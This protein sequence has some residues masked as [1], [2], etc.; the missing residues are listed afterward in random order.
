[1]TKIIK[2]AACLCGTVIGLNLLASQAMAAACTSESLAA[3]IALA[4]TGCTVGD[5]TFSNFSEIGSGTGTVPTPA[6]ITV[7]PDT[8]SIPG[9]IGLDFNSTWFAGT[10]QTADTTITFDVSIVGGGPMLIT[11]ASTVQSS[12]GFTGTG[13]ATVTEGI[14]AGP[15]CTPTTSTSTVN[16]AGTTVLADT[17]V[18]A[19]TGAIQA[20]KDL[21]VVGGS[22]GTA[23]ISQVF[24][25]F[26][27]T[28]VPEPGSI[29]L[30]GTA[31]LG[32]VNFA[33]KRLAH[34]A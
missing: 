18:F 15:P 21:G 17:K 3:Y 33:R 24:D 20:V 26:S 1:M 13:A 9:E 25:G 4:A 27:Q 6:G 30:L 32:V 11:D 23:S 10:G 2:T 7:T 16:S 19:P 22:S 34:R 31:I 5:K 12:S 28:T 8:L 29:L 14:C